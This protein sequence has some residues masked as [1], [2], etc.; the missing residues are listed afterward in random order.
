[1]ENETRRQRIEDIV[2]ECIDRMNQGERLTVEQVRED[3]PELAEE[4][5]NHLETFVDLPSMGEEEPLGTLG[6]YRLRCQIGRGGMG[7]VY[8]AWENSMDR[9][10]ALKVLPTGIAA[11]DKAVARFV[12]EARLAGKLNHPNVVGVYGMGVKEQTPYYAMEFVEGETLAQVL[13]KLKAADPEEET[14][15]G[16]KDSVVYFGKLSEAFADVA[17]GL[18]HAHSKGIIHRDIKPSNLILDREGS[19]RILDFGLARLEGQESLTISGDVVGTPLYMSPEQARRKKIAVD[20]RTDVYSLGA[21]LYEMLTLEPPFRG[22]DHE[23]T[24]SQIIE[25]DP[26]EPRKINARVPR[27]IE[28]IVLKCLRKEQGDRYGTAEAMGQDLRRFVRG[29]PIEAR[30]QGEWEKLIRRL[31]LHRIGLSVT[32]VVFVLLCVIGWLAWKSA[33][34]AYQRAL[35]DYRPRVLRALMKLQAG[36]INIRAEAG[37]PIAF[38]L[39]NHGFNLGQ[40]KALSRGRLEPIQQAVR[41]LGEA[42]D[43]LPE[44]PDALYHRA[45]G[46]LLLGKDDEALR[47]IDHAL[48]CAPRFVPALMLRA[49]ILERTGQKEK[50]RSLR[51]RVEGASHDRWESAWLAARHALR[52]KQWGDAVQAFGTLIQLEADGK[53]AYLGSAIESCLGRAGASLELKDF[54]GTVQDTAVARYLWPDSVEARLLEGKALYLMGQSEKARDLF[55]KTYDVAPN[56]DEVAVAVWIIINQYLNDET[57]ALRWASRVS[58]ASLRERFRATSLFFLGRGV[59]GMAAA[60]KAIALDP[61][62]AWSHQWLGM[63]LYDLMGDFEGGL[64]ALR[65]AERLKPDDPFTYYQL[66]RLFWFWGKFDDAVLHYR[67]AIKLD[68]TQA[69]A[70]TEL[71]NCL[72]RQGKVEEA[73]R[74]FDEAVQKDPMNAIVWNDIALAYGLL[75]REDDALTACDAAIHADPNFSWPRSRRAHILENK[76]RTEEAIEEYR[77]ACPLSPRGPGPY[78]DLGRLLERQGKRDEAFSVYLEA[79]DAVPPNGVTLRRVADLFRRNDGVISVGKIA[80]LQDKLPKIIEA[81]LR[82]LDHS[83]ASGTSPAGLVCTLTEA[84]CALGPGEGNA[85]NRLRL[86]PRLPP[87]AVIDRLLLRDADLATDAAAQAIES[88]HAEPDTPHAADCLEYLEAKAL[89]RA[90]RHQEAASRFAELAEREATSEEPPLALALNLRASGDSQGAE[91]AL[92]DAIEKLPRAGNGLWNLWAALSLNLGRDPEDLL[93]DPIVSKSGSWGSREDLQWLLERLRDREAIRIN[94]GGG[95]TT[96]PDGRNWSRDR[97]AMGGEGSTLYV[98]EIAETDADFLYQSER[99]FSESERPGAGYHVPLP[100]GGYRVSLH[101]AEVSWRVPGT[102]SFDVVIEGRKVLGGFEPLLF[103]FATA[104]IETTVVQVEDGML[105]I[106]LV[107]GNGNP[108]VSGIEIEWAE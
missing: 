41:E 42:V 48:H 80:A 66:G 103:G 98:G 30:P 102:R 75:G 12:R 40:L 31:R 14:L 11:D 6:D 27:G 91:R 65:D 95:D 2:A 34:E 21:T 97:F 76:G 10:V 38:D 94:C 1:V 83:D 45:R 88:F 86:L 28:T 107:H 77:R 67:K 4:I 90:G 78:M 72:I 105:D 44:R 35:S 64:A 13:A 36:S 9:R 20:H 79:L 101:F 54:V 68:P 23:D 22:K 16:K 81:L 46:H 56:K 15:F 106:E 59:D 49:A 60:R 43:L 57:V 32:A 33:H 55:E 19:L 3:H 29:D 71:G 82:S 61:Q 89:E 8:E 50:A 63:I 53:E 93:A 51:E 104:R 74:L 99:W 7:V 69:D 26:V 17:D 108:T 37:E 18:Q 58:I 39:R 92:R 25:R 24:L 47:D 5:L 70:W 52:E 85:W 84:I 96:S 73:M 100:P 62:D 87:Y